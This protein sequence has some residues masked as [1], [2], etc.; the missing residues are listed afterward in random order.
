MKI[1][2]LIDEKLNNLP[3]Y[4][5]VLYILFGYTAVAFV[6]S[7]FG[8]L[9]Y[10]FLGMLA[11]LLV[12]F[13][14]ALF[15]NYFF[16]AIWRLP[17][18]YESVLMTIL[19]LFLILM[20]L[21]VSGVS[22]SEIWTQAWPIVLVT[23]SAI[24]S[25]YIFVF[26]KTHI[27]NPAAFGLFISYLFSFGIAFWW[28]GTPAIVPFIVVG[29]LLIAR[30]NRKT[31]FV[32]AA[33]AISILTSLTVA[34][35]GKDEMMQSMRSLYI[36]GPLIFFFTVM[37]TEPHT[38]PGKKY[39]Q[40]IFFIFVA[41]VS[42]MSLFNLP[43][44]FSLLLANLLT[45]VICSKRRLILKLKEKNIVGK[46]IVE[47]VFSTNTKLKF[48]A[49]QYLEWLVLTKENDS[50]GLRRFFTISSSPDM[51]SGLISF[52]T[53]FPPENMSVYKKVLN[54]MKTGDT[55]Y[56]SQLAGDFILPEKK[57][58]EV[59]MVAGGIGVTPFISQL[60]EMLE[61]GEKRKVTLIYCVKD[62][63]EVAYK[64]IL[65]KAISE[66]GIKV[67]YQT[68][69]LNSE[70]LKSYNLN[71]KE[72]DI[73]ISGPNRMVDAYESTFK[74][75]GAKCIHTDFFPGFA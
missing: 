48:T 58:R 74:A 49:G 7:L 68:Q 5:L 28:V 10:G 69:I 64:G 34:Y 20:P 41:M 30:K 52:S 11:S 51:E 13:F 38:M 45:F 9:S 50:R 36:S 53:K 75:E 35:F 65:D 16:T 23:F 55:M 61:T 6:L 26:R 59:V 29:G 62:L 24:A 47:F 3:M 39:A 71:L 57:E 73:Y 54:E 66:L 18:N 44:E 21:E 8:L 12:I 37:L 15:T 67:I 42:T 33:I 19:I 46:S 31:R 40:Y 32:L 17:N 70:I 2:N 4:K 22:L 14:T 1:L 72:S 56:A 27:F 25:K 43:L 60:R 63:E